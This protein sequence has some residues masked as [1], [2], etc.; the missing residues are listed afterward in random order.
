MCPIPRPRPGEQPQGARCEV[1]GSLD[2]RKHCT[3][4]LLNPITVSNRQKQCCE[5]KVRL[6]SWDIASHLL[7][8]EEQEAPRV[9]QRCDACAALFLH[10]T[11]PREWDGAMGESSWCV[12]PY[13]AASA[14][15]SWGGGGG[16]LNEH[17]GVVYE[18]GN[19][20]LPQDKT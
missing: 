4:C 14:G 8:R 10:K 19:R 16:A 1:F 3:C 2:L 18:L 9:E 13:S 6:Q 15:C 17:R 20:A 12:N 11:A 5:A 7:L